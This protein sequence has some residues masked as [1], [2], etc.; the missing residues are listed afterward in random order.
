MQSK[1]VMHTK[2]SGEIFLS[3]FAKNVKQGEIPLGTD[4]KAARKKAAE[5]VEAVRGSDDIIDEIT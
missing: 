5:F 2:I 1:L 3:I 4:A